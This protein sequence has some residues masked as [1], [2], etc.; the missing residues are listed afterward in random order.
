MRFCQKNLQKIK[1][2]KNKNGNS[3]YVGTISEA[4]FI[5]EAEANIQTA[6]NKL[7]AEIYGERVGEMLALYCSYP[8][9]INNGD[10]VGIYDCNSFTHKVVSVKLYKLHAV[11]LV[12]RILNYESNC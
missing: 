2:F 6:E 11:L 3:N 9:K 4:V 8:L 12:E 5:G 1:L 7:N 10:Y